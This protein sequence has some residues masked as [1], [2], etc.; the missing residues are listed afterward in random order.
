MD[1]E[2]QG[3]NWNPGSLALNPTKSQLLTVLLEHLEKMRTVI[4]DGYYPSFTGGETG[5]KVPIGPGPGRG[6]SGS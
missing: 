3:Q 1:E 5:T 6:P 4:A 2:W